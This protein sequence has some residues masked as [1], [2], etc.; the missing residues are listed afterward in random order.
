MNAMSLINEITDCALDSTN[1]LNSNLS[2]NVLDK[3]GD[4]FVFLVG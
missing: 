2:L 4:D 3:H 1:F